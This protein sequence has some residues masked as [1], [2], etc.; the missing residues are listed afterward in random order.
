LFEKSL[1]D[2]LADRDAH[3]SKKRISSKPKFYT[4]AGTGNKRKGGAGKR[5][6]GAEVAAN[7]Y[8]NY[9]KKLRVSTYH[10]PPPQRS[11]CGGLVL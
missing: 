2:K 5:G 3:L 6:G 10:L 8:I 4:P 7:R 9:V 1:D 11:R